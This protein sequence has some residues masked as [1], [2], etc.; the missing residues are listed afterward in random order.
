MRFNMYVG[1]VLLRS[2]HLESLKRFQRLNNATEKDEFYRQLA[3]ILTR[4]YSNAIIKTGHWPVFYVEGIQ[5][6]MNE[7]VVKT[8]KKIAA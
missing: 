5:S 2:I 4:R 8:I 7:A 6:K 3:V 1:P